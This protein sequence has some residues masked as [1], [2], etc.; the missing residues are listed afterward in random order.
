MALT[1][2]ADQARAAQFIVD[3]SD[4]LVEEGVKWNGWYKNDGA[5][6]HGLSKEQFFLERII[7]DPSTRWALDF[8]IQVKSWGKI[9]S[10]DQSGITVEVAK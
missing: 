2:S 4:E 10:F 9:R 7:F 6:R 1:F 3:V 5:E 8:F